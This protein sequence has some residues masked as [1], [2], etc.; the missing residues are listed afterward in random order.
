MICHSPYSLWIACI[1][2]A[3]GSQAVPDASRVSRGSMM[4]DAGA[5]GG[6]AGST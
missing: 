4:L 2:D 3:S 5:A 6:G 1:G